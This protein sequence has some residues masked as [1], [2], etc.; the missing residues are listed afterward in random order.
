MLGMAGPAGV[1]GPG[2]GAPLPQP[3]SEAAASEP[4]RVRE[5]FPETMYWN[6]SLITDEHG[7]AS[8]TL[9]MADSITTWRMSMLANSAR[10]L[11]GSGTAPLRVFQPFFV[12]IDLPVALTQHDEIA[13]PVVV[14]NYLPQA[15]QVTLTL[16]MGNWFVLNGEM[17]VDVQLAKDQVKVVY[18][19]LSIRE[20][21][22]HSLTVFAKS[23]V[24]S[25]AIKRTITVLPN[26][27]EMR[28]AINDRL[29]AAAEHTVIIPEEA[30]D[31]AQNLWVKFYPG[32]FSQVLE[33]ADGMLRM[34]SGCFEQTS[35]TTYPNILVLDYMKTVKKINPE[36]QMKA[37]QYINVGYQRLVTYECKNGGFSWFGNEPAHQI[38]TA[39]GLLE[40]SDMAKVHDVDP[41][42]INRT[43]AWLAGKQLA[44]GTW[45]VT[46]Q[47]IAEGII[48]RQT[49]ALRS[50]AYIAWVLAESGYRGAEVAR[51][52]QYLKA[53]R[54]EA[55]DAYTLAILL[56][57][58]TRIDREGADAA[59]T[60]NAL[61]A[62]AKV[63]EK[64]AYW[65]SDTQTFTGANSAGADLETSGLA[66]FGL[67]KWG[68]NS[69]FTGKVLT[70]LLQSKD[71][72]GTWST[73]QGTVWSLK[74]LILASGSAVGGAK[75]EVTVLVN[76]QPAA[77]F[78]VTEEDSDVMRQFDLSGKIHE[79]ENRVALK[80][81]GDGG[82][83]YQIV[84]R[85]Y[86]PWEVV[87][88]RDDLKGP[89][90]ITLVYDKT[91]LAQD[92]TATVTATISNTTDA[93]VEM[94]LIDLGLPPGFTLDAEALETA[95][96]EG[97]I[98]KFTVAARQII[99]Y[100]E[101]LA[102]QTTITLHYK[103]KAKYPI[104]A[105]SAQSKAYPYYNPEKANIAAPQTVTVQ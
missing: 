46:E 96:Q 49:G 11:L 7:E 76:G 97:R 3:T 45:N 68:R 69:G 16:E 4:V 28:D 62:L 85:Y 27:K 43:Q 39:Y 74:A 20:I 84:S 55:T 23:E 12:D 82:L 13:I 18:F 15:Q 31:N 47:G 89:L 87:A 42:L 93:I 30:I 33:G 58:F 8:I 83:I 40:F 64:T 88:E 105:Q 14:Y 100:M 95:V 81:A 21:G 25:D 59:A 6:P 92:D 24:M 9:P 32:A 35:S 99:I 90:D 79:G 103:L 56:N 10:G 51:A 53:H 61:I 54:A 22:R 17:D 34:P 44:D 70:H 50:T 36:I 75:G 86:L 1:N 73:T 94:P 60:A 5:Y 71:S 37:E 78:T 57:L 29:D 72:F 52:V 41:A 48:N 80:F 104:K 91:T 19:R 26:G 98:S 38:L 77:A 65:E 67:V 66:A 63:T 2:G 102:P 101:Q